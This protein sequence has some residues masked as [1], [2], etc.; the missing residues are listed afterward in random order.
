[1]QS[2]LV[3]LEKS[4]HGKAVLREIVLAK[5][6]APVA[7]NEEITCTCSDVEESGEFSYKAV[8]TKGTVKVPSSSC[9]WRSSK[10]ER[11]EKLAGKT[12]INRT[13]SHEATKARR[14]TALQN[15]SFLRVSVA[16]CENRFCL[17]VSF[18]LTV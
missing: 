11:E 7:P 1:M 4:T 10:D 12:G 18:L 9:G 14:R 15:C 8:I 3:T 16:S 6:F 5:Y 2:A 13:I 17:G